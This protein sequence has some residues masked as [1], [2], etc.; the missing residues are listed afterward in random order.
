MQSALVGRLVELDRLLGVLQSASGGMAG[1]ALVGGD[2]GIGKTRLVTE[3]AE[4]A[5][6]KGLAVLV[7]QCAEL[8]DALPY[9][10]LAD[11]L[12]GAEESCA[13]RSRRVPCSAGCCPG[14][15]TPARRAPRASPSSSCSA[16]C[17]GSWPPS[18]S[19]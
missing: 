7:G 12:R 3:L 17:S 8:G 16:R 6:E 19:S 10:P 18:R 13:R 14:S 1:V 2:A 11:A 9:L 5:R 15:P 4:R